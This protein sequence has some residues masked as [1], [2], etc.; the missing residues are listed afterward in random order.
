MKKIDDN[1]NIGILGNLKKDKFYH[2]F[3]E[4]GV[5]LE[6]NSINFYLLENDSMDLEK[7]FYKDRIANFND[8]INQAD[9]I[10][11]IG[12][13]GTIISSIRKFL[14]YDKPILGLHIGGLGFLAECN[15]ENYK[16]KFLDIKKGN[17]YIEDRMLLNVSSLE[18]NINYDIINELVIDRRDSARTIKTNIAISGKFANT[19]E[20]DGI[21]FST[22]T[23]ST[24]YSLSAGGPIVYPS[25]EVT[26]ITPICPHTLSMRPL[27]IP[28]SDII[29]IDFDNSENKKLSLTVDGQ[30]QKVIGSDSKILLKKSRH[31]AHL[32]KFNKYD[33]FSTLRDKMYWKG[34]LRIK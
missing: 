18:K 26:L 21:I 4:L 28:A 30:I 1:I 9:I 29:E 17:Y 34:N 20:S 13:D 2:I 11:S 22:P 6:S 15:N 24:A 14:K 10:L 27:I 25:M 12:G 8:I 7:I 5:F 19:Y 33:Y 3:N 32:I 31:H 23:G 16:E